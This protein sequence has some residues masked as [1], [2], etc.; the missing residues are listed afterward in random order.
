MARHHGLFVPCQ[1]P[2]SIATDL[3]D[4]TWRWILF[5]LSVTAGRRP[6]DGSRL[7][8]STLCASYER[9]P[10][11]CPPE[12]KAR[13]QSTTQQSELA[14]FWDAKRLDLNN[15]RNLRDAAYMGTDANR[16]PQ[17]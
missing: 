2:D 17:S 4:N 1:H 9:V 13:E 8:L 3:M 14:Y 5:Q 15:D 11:L 16:F 6:R 10:S 7:V 12:C